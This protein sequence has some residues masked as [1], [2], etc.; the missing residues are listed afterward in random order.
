MVKLSKRK[1][2]RLKDYN[3]SDNGWYFVTI[4]SKDRK[5]LFGEYS[6]IVGAPLVCAPTLSSIMRFFKSKTFLDYLNY[7][8]QNNTKLSVNIWQR[9]FYEHVIRNDYSLRAVRKYISEN[10]ANWEQD[11]D[12]L[13][14]L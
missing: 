7:L 1:N 2:Y 12:Y 5:N 11:I 9:S 4:C 6:K 14:N 10:P 3:Y 13:F 8:K